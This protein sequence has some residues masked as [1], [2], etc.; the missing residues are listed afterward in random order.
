M[1]KY[2][3]KSKQEGLAG[4]RHDEERVEEVDAWR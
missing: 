4:F 1:D 2:K 3:G